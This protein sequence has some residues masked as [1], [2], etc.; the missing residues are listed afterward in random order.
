VHFLYILIWAEYNIRRSKLGKQII[1]AC[2]V[3][4]RH[5][6]ECTK[7]SD[8]SYL[9]CD[10]PKW[11]QWRVDGRTFR[12]AANTRSFAGVQRAAELK[13][14]E[15][16]GEVVNASPEVKSVEAA[17]QEWLAFRT[18]NGLNNDRTKLL[19]NK[20]VAWCKAN[21][22][23]FLH[24]LTSDKVLAFRNSLPY[25]TATSSSLKIHWAVMSGFFGWAHGI[26][27]IAK[28]PV[29]NTRVHPQF[30]IR[31]KKPEVV[32]PTTAEVNSVIAAV[33]KAPWDDAT[34]RRVRLFMLTQ[35]WT[36][37]AIMDTATLRRDRLGDD[38]RIRGNRRKTNERFKVRIPQAL[39]D[40]L[41]ALPCSDQDFFFWNLRDG[42]KTKPYSIRGYYEVKLRKVFELAGVKMTSH[43][44]RHFFVTQELAEGR[45]VDDVSKMIG[46][47]PQE[48]RKTYHHWIKEDDARMD[49]IQDKIW[50]ERGLDG[51]QPAEKPKP[52]ASA[53]HPLKAQSQAGR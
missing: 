11:L 21:R 9:K 40:Q 18:T 39:A 35:R 51:G 19:G 42:H 36:G 31:F 5:S 25:K 28:N 53:R 32:P 47:S 38:N 24:Q 8:A 29:P 45:S 10:C 27:L 33:E 23:S 44:F 37:M 22:I 4:S 17:I 49:A 12:E 30:K 13:T 34:K 15:L 1:G 26:E 6:E 16:S 7:K 46:T 3:Y 2:R 48:I 14:K 41:R 20:L 50:Q 43:G 52:A